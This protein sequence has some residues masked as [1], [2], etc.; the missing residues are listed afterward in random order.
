MQAVY[1]ETTK[2]NIFEEVVGN[3][4]KISSMSV[5]NTLPDDKASN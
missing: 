2:E 3:T 4:I 1:M 5:D